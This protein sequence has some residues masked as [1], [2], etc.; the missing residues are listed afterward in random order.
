MDWHRF[1]TIA[2][3]HLGLNPCSATSK[4]SW[5][6]WTTFERIGEDAGY[7]TAPLPLETEIL[8][9]GT[10][11]GGTW[12]QPFRYEQLAHFI[13]PRRFYWEEISADGFKS[14][15]HEQDI[16]GL[17]HKLT[18][19]GMAHRLTELVLEVKLY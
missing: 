14:G 10:S 9:D 17:S 12:G 16:E 18:I 8:A 2:S 15:V 4:W 5:C 19:A 13:I 7:W 1:L 6:A 11:D 3:N